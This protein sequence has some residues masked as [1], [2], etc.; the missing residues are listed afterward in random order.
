MVETT[1]FALLKTAVFIA[2]KTIAPMALPE[3]VEIEI[4]DAY[5]NE[6]FCG[7]CGKLV[8]KERRKPDIDSRVFCSENCKSDITV[9]LVFA[10]NA[11]WRYKKRAVFL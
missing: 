4:E 6:A 8:S 2:M 11:E 9:E 5:V 3:E 10:Q 7:K 1:K